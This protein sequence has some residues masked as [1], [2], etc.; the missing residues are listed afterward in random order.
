MRARVSTKIGA[1][2]F[3][4]LLVTLV[5]H[6]AVTRTVMSKEVA[7]LRRRAGA[8]GLRLVALSLSGGPHAF[9][10]VATSL[11]RGPS[12]GVYDA[13]GKAI[14]RVHRAP[15]RLSSAAMAQAAASPEPIFLAE[16]V[17]V[18]ALGEAQ[19]GARFVALIEGGVE[20]RL[21]STR[22]KILLLVSMASVLFGLIASV[23]LSRRIRAR[24][25]E[26]S[27]VVRRVAEGELDVRLPV[28][29][30]DEIGQLARDFNRMAEALG[31]HI[32][33][34]RR[35]DARRRRTLADWTHE[36]ATPL[37]SVIGYLEA[38]RSGR[39]DA[40]RTER[41][42]RQAHEQAK[43]LEHLTEDLTVLSQLDAEGVALARKD[44]DL[45]ALLEAEL[46]ASRVRAPGL[47][48]VRAGEAELCVSLDPQRFSQILRNVLANAERY[49][50]AR[51]TVS[52]ARA[53]AH[54][55][56]AVD[57][58]GEGIAPEHLAHVTE[59]FYRVDSS[60]DRKTGGRGLGLSIASRLARAHGGRLE[61][62]SRV[63]EGTRVLV[64]IPASTDL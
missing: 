6:V 23:V 31:R 5:A 12:I 34:L 14:A 1:A 60:R 19:G 59:S 50:R 17:G 41:Y 32:D 22:V 53:G 40:A 61:V 38:L 49:A 10:T 45:I 2:V 29:S 7:V 15:A 39:L 36:I 56:L 52:C 28:S 48:F 42:L 30:D 44:V 55:A 11:E 35:E 58:D 26:T 54:V 63:G 57:D 46:D 13:A 33:A 21:R 8:H 20:E 51:V 25:L 47:T 62:S 18:L 3:A 37:T 9:E 64:E 24:L 4:L 27:G 43:A 16:G